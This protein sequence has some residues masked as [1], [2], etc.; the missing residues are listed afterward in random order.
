MSGTFDLYKEVTQTILDHL[1]AGV[2]PWR[3][4]WDA[5][6]T[7]ALPLR[8]TGEAYRGVNVVLL[9]QKMVAQGYRARTWMT[10]AQ[11]TKLGGQVRK[12]EK[13]T[14]VVKMGRHV[15][16]GAVDARTGEREE[17]EV[18]RFMR[19]YRVF[20]VEQ[21]DGLDASFYA[22]P[23]PPRSFGTRSDPAV[24]AWLAR[25]GIALEVTGEPRAYY[26]IARDVI[27]MPPAENFGDG[28]GH[29]GTLLHEAAHATGHRTRL[30]R[31]FGTAFGDADYCQEEVVA[32]LGSAMVGAQLGVEPRFEQ[33]AAYLE[34]WTR[35]LRSDAR[36]VMRAAS[37]A[38]A[39]SDWL[40]ARGGLLEDPALLAS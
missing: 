31:R 10:Y 5:G 38:Q 13:S 29:A 20:H 17:D 1:E 19:A 15:T 4:P 33:N 22:A 24:L 36:A 18:R 21:I 30:K 6:G 14:R 3:K 28:A 27:H 39:A 8:V 12:G 2:V 25:T 35:V 40:I 16:Q 26:D 32:E 23:T 7:P 37:A 11:A 9:W 34:A